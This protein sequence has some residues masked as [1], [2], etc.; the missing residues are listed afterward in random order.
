MANKLNY[1]VKKWVALDIIK[2][3]CV[4]VMVF[5]HAHMALITEFNVIT[6]TL[7]FYYEITSKFMFIGLFLIALPIIAG[8]ILRMN[9][10]KN[11]VRGK[12]KDYKLGKIIWIA[13]FISLLGFFMN[14]ITWGFEYAFSWNVLQLIGL[15]FVVIAIL[16]K[17]FSV[18]AVFLTGLISMFAIEPL[19]SFLGDL[20]YIYFISIFIGT[21]DYHT[22]WSF[23]PWFS[24]VAFGFLFAHYYL[25]YKNS[26]KF[27]ISA[28]AVGIILIDIAIFRNE[29][30]PY[31]DPGYV[32]GPSL[33]QPTIGWIFASIGF[34]CV[35]TIVGN[36]F[37]NKIHLRKY[38]IINSYSKG[39]LWIYII[40]MFVS[41][42][43][44]LP[45]KRIFPMD[46]PSYAYFILPIF[47]LLLSWLVGALS[48]KL[49]Q[50]KKVVITLKKIQ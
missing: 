49:L 27:R 31:L 13:V 46:E 17:V 24:V 47:I 26:A 35:L 19:R 6:N 36:T 2:F 5:V 20:D 39:I 32:W 29:I 9:F 42:K 38:G 12:L 18:H 15:S 10:G 11:L 33:S 14:I 41:Q 45:I 43:L 40:Q 4:A 8:A 44:S 23:F 37:F 48:I 3:V 21:S 7:G 16:L 28:L 25:R 22:F 34:F 50:E 1:Y 30:S